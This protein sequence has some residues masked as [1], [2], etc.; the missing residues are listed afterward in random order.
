MGCAFKYNS[1]EKKFKLPFISSTVT[2]ELKA[3]SYIKNSGLEKR[4]II[5]DSLK[6]PSC[7]SEIQSFSS[8]GTEDSVYNFFFHENKQVFHYLQKQG[9][10]V[11]C[12]E[13]DF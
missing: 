6:R 13:N 12:N 9:Y 1:I 4:L 2:G 10:I 8:I 7:H 5:S 11:M 3:L